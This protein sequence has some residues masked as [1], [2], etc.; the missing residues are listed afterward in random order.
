MSNQ[1]NAMITDQ[2]IERGISD[3][4][5][6]AAMRA[7]LRENFVP[8]QEKLHAYSDGPLPIGYGQTISQPYIVATMTES[9]LIQKTDKVLEIGTG[10]GYGAAVLSQIAHSVY[11]C[12]RIDPL[13]KLAKERFIKLEYHN[14]HCICSDGSIGW[15]E[16]APFDAILVTASA[17][18]AP[19]SLLNQLT[20]GGRLVIPIGTEIEQKLYRIIRTSENDFKKEVLLDVRFVPLIG[21][22]GWDYRS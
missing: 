7:V 2:I 20:I 19:K 13:V 1:N 15:K 21:Q 6:I 8:G 10:S 9:A 22:E 5:V 16:E 3:P 12:D 17:P 4:N 14:I 11:T 18:F